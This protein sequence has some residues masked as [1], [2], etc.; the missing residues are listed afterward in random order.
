MGFFYS[1]N[2]KLAPPLADQRVPID[3]VLELEPRYLII[4]DGSKNVYRL[5]DILIPQ[6]SSDLLQIC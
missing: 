3:N 4:I 5:Y 6:V 2:L 1:K